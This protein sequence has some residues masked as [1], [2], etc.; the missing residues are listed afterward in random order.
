MLSVA[1]VIP[2]SPSPCLS[3]R[4]V[5]ATTRADSLDEAAKEYLI[6]W[7]PALGGVPGPVTDGVTATDPI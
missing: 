5:A 7:M 4:T 6:F 3:P 1:P 2:K